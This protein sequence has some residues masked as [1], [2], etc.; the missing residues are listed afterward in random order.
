MRHSKIFPGAPKSA[1]LRLLYYNRREKAY[2][3]ITDI[4]KSIV[5]ATREQRDF[6]SRD[7]CLSE[8]RVANFMLVEITLFAPLI[9]HNVLFLH[10]FISTY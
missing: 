9:L 10:F 4:G 3:L 2:F 5:C 1:I 7:C 8:A 6:D